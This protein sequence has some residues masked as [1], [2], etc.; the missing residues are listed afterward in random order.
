[1]L[2]A[3]SDA[4]DSE[5]TFTHLGDASLVAT[6]TYVPSALR[7]Q[8]IALQ[9]VAALID[10]AAQSGRTIIPSCSYVAARMRERPEW[11]TLLH[12]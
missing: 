1:M 3:R 9:L 4:G 12:S 2:V 10:Y 8:G 6:R 5:L 7:H 11:S